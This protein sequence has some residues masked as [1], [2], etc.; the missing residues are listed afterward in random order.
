MPEIVIYAIGGRSDDQ[1]KSLCKD[2]TTP[3]EE[4]KVPASGGDH[5]GRDAQDR[6]G[7]RRMFS[8]MGAR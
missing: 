5:P 3:V 2:I 6:R 7:G 4:P 1:K 8:E